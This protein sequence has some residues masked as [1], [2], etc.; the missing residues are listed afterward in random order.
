MPGTRLRR[1]LLG[2]NVPDRELAHLGGE[3][4]DGGF[5]VEAVLGSQTVSEPAVPVSSGGAGRPRRDDDDV[6]ANALGAEL[7]R[8]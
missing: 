7:V 5:A 2:P 1:R 8:P 4:F 3:V 6:A